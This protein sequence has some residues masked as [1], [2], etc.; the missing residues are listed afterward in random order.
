MFPMKTVSIDNIKIKAQLTEI[1]SLEDT[2]E[3]SGQGGS[4]RAAVYKMRNYCLQSK[5]ELP[6]AE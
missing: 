1:G 6:V 5:W 4:S 3:R 2:G